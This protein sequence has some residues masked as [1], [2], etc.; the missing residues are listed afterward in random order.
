MSHLTNRQ[1][2]AEI[3]R[4]DRLVERLAK[5]L[6]EFEDSRHGTTAEPRDS[7]KA[8][9]AGDGPREPGKP[10]TEA[11]GSDRGSCEDVEGR[12]KAPDESADLTQGLK[13]YGK[14]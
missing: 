4:L 6:A 13:P 10:D 12:E 8:S 1:L 2:V 3:D 7:R 11:M 5:R 14:E 9:S